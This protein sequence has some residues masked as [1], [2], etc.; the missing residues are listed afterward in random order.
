MAFSVNTPVGDGSTVQFA[1][2]FVNG[3]FS[4]ESVTVFVDGEIDGGGDPLPRAFIWIND[5][6]I[7]LVGAAP[8][9]GVQVTIRR[10]MDK[11]QPA[12]DY[13]DGSILVEANMDLSLDQLLNSIHEVLD[14]YGFENVQT[15]INMNGNSILNLATSVDAS[16]AVSRGEAIALINAQASGLTARRR[17]TRKIAAQDQT[18][19]NL[20]DVT[21]VPAINN[22]QV[23][24]NGVAQVSSVDYLE[25]DLNTIT[26]LSGLAAGDAVD[27]YVNEA[28]DST[29]DPIARDDIATLNTQV[30]NRV[31]RVS[32]RTEMK[33]YAVPAG[34]Q[35]S[36]EEGGRSGLFVVKVGT[37]SA[38]TLEG[39][40]IVL[41]NG[42]YAERLNKAVLTPETFGAVGDNIAN[43]TTAFQNAL[44]FA[45]QKVLGRRG[46]TYLLTAQCDITSEIELDLNGSVLNFQLTSLQAGVYIKSNNV[47]IHNGGIEVTGSAGAQTGGNGHSLNCVTSGVQSNGTGWSGQ[48]VHH[49]DVTTNR[50]DAGAHIGFIGECFNFNI[51][52]ITVR[53]NAVCR[54]IIGVE[55]G[56]LAVPG[57]T[58]HPHDGEISNIHIGHIT[59][60]TYGGSGYAFGL[61]VS[62]AFNIAIKNI[63]MLTGYGLLM[64][65][66]GDNANTYART[67]YKDLIGTGI[68]FNNLS[69]ASCY[70]Y[71]LRVVGSH[72]SGTLDNI[73]MG[74]VGSNLKI[75]GGK[76]GANNNFGMGFEQC[77][78]VSLTNVFISGAHAAGITT[79]VNAHKVHIENGHILDSELYGASISNNAADFSL[80]SV[81]FAQNNSNAA[82]GVGTAAVFIGESYNVVLQDCTF[83]VDGVADT[84]KYSVYTNSS[85][86]RPKLNGLHTYSQAAG[87]VSY[88][89]GSSADTEINAQGIDNTSEA[90]ISNAGGAPIFQT[91]ANG[92]RTFTS[93]AIPTSGTYAQGDKVY[94]PNPAASGSIG[95]VCVTDGSPGVWKNWGSIDA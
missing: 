5:G 55:W 66:R 56:G 26:F 57:G 53:D 49:L 30:D 48:H 80:K 60:P 62:A 52:D 78:G 76:V 27:M 39:V 33:A 83:G 22:I 37:P 31:I 72:L 75:V 94:F 17:E 36:L 67:E 15:D 40:Y 23:Y 41:D 86:R 58:G 47:E 9:V 91:S 7:E 87:G 92:D 68:T 21:Y 28:T 50:T 65:I 11:T 43:D 14:G 64:C 82:G 70:G 59:T 85:A 18:V 79:G 63:S 51:H 8:G 45:E 44:A 81:L 13:T 89:I 29:F 25:T 35:F 71:G 42:N 24:V 88:V 74:V 2:N 10:I 77:R 12:V 38:D 19:F 90:G 6:L 16:A 20:A 1:V 95:A 73:D 54:N 4:R 93:G 34:Y 61:W 46:A 3:L 84:Q 32:S 69:I